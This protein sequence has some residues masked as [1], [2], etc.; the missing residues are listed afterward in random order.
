V[1]AS[2]SN[3]DFVYFL[4][5]QFSFNFDI[6][7]VKEVLMLSTLNLIQEQNQNKEIYRKSDVF[8]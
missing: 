5:F 1:I 3:F 7:S 6:I 2:L 4:D 8:G